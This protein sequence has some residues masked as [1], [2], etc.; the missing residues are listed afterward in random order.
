[1]GAGVT[2]TSVGKTVEAAL[3]KEP[4]TAA[5][6]VASEFV[7]RRS[8][9]AGGEAEMAARLAD[10]DGGGRSGGGGARGRRRQWRR[11]VVATT[12]EWEGE[13]EEETTLEREKGGWRLGFGYG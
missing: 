10:G 3:G 11:R 12:G 7:Q 4:T 1:M 9:T 6:H 13:G 2:P 8:A 5:D